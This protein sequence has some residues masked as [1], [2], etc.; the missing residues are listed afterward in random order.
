MTELCLLQPG[1][2]PVFTN[3]LQFVFVTAAFVVVVSLAVYY[4][5]RGLRKSN[6]G[7]L[8]TQLNAEFEKSKDALLLAAQAKKAKKEAEAGAQRSME[9]EAK[10]MELLRENVDPARVFGQSDPYSGI[11]MMEDSEL[12]IDP[13][14][15]QGYFLSSFLN[16]W[17]VDLERPK[18]VF[19]YPQGT[20]VKTSEMLKVF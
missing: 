2:S 15:G 11:E 13:Y 8:T 12:I 18:Y 17:P 20:V 14:T 16:D 3:A 10:E 9:V 1:A 19:R 4:V 5:L 7:S 6:D